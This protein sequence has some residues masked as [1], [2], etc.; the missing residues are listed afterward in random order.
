MFSH[1][2]VNGEES[3]PTLFRRLRQATPESFCLFF[4]LLLHRQEVSEVLR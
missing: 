4:A 3:K 2:G 1:N